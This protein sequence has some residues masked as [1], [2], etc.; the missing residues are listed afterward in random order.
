VKK[1]REI[2]AHIRTDTEAYPNGE[3]QGTILPTR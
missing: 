3:I 2:G 1:M